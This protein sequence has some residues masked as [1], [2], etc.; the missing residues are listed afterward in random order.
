M[1][2]TP[3]KGRGW[4][5]DSAAFISIKSP[6]LFNPLTTGGGTWTARVE[7]EP[8]TSPNGGQVAMTWRKDMKDSPD[9]T[10]EN[11]KAAILNYLDNRPDDEQ[12]TRKEWAAFQPIKE[13]L[14]NL[15]GV[16]AGRWG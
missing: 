12:G 3:I 9:F 14:E 11:L 8:P 4:R 16:D 6:A 7:H 13:K 15:L 10:F 1:N 5:S 2:L